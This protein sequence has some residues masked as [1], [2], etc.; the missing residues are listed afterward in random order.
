L[1][2][3]DAAITAIQTNAVR[4]YLHRPE[5]PT[6]EGLVLTHGAGANANSP[7]LQAVA[8]A[9]AASG[10]Q[11]LRC[12]LPFRQKR[13][14]GPPSPA[15]AEGDRRGLR[16][17]ID[18]MRA[19]CAGRVFAGGHSY[20]GRQASILVSED[21]GFLDGLLLL[22]YP[23]HP[24]KKPATLRTA[25]FPALRTPALFVHGTRDPFGSIEELATALQLIPAPTRIATVESGH[26][27]L[28]GKFDI[29]AVIVQPF[30]DTLAA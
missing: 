14:F 21:P 30:R 22:S 2:Q 12:D 17:A 11:V 6:G 27:L 9:F 25:H 10:I 1:T 5:N 16:A 20:G 4:G 8:A 7:L 15:T 24:P 18:E 3:R 28:Q 29:A 23:L 19:I 13:P 26:D